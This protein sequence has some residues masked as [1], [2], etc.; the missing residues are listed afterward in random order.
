MEFRGKSFSKSMGN[1]A[2]STGISLRMDITGDVR[3]KGRGTEYSLGRVNSFRIGWSAKVN[4]LCWGEVTWSKAACMGMLTG[5]GEETQ[6]RSMVISR[7][8]DCGNSDGNSRGPGAVHA[9]VD[10]IG[11]GGGHTILGA[12]KAPCGV[13]NCLIK[14]PR[15]AL[16]GNSVYFRGEGSMGFTSLGLEVF[17]A[18]GESLWVGVSDGFASSKP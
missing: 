8:Y 6:P 13:N 4:S 5:E 1:G 11:A 2:G 7:M 14:V 3:G 12:A 17:K 9:F 18:L 15:P 10:S 16:G